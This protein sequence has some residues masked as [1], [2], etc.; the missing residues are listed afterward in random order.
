MSVPKNQVIKLKHRL[1]FKYHIKEDTQKEYYDTHI[2]DE[3]D[4][5]SQNGEPKALLYTLQI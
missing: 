2:Q 3:L 1:H 5:I 4:L